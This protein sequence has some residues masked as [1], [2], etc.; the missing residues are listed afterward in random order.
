[1]KMAQKDYY[2]VLGVSRDASD[3]EI[4]A[5]YRKLARKFHPDV[6]KGS[7]EA[8]ERFKEVAEAFAVL[9]DKEKRARYDAVGHGAFGGRG[10]ADPFAGFDPR[11]LDLGFGDM[12]SLLEQMFGIRGGGRRTVQRRGRDL[13]AELR[14][15]FLQAVQGGTMEIQLP[16]GGPGTE[17]VKV[18]IPAGVEDGATLRLAGKGQEG[19]AGAGDAYLTIRVEGHPLF[20][21]EGRDLYVEVPVGIVRAT[22]G[23][24]VTVPTLDGQATVQLP[25]GT[26]SGRKLRLKGKGV[27]ARGGPGNLYAVIRIEPPTTLDDRSRELLE[28]LARHNPN[29]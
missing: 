5:A 11:D 13:R 17:A 22:L 23:G 14:V 20:R 16:R 12:S 6:N 1:M 21:R 15:P 19:P 25:A 26:A 7:A 24:G 2:E 4:K 27:P 3:K 29:A 18:R 9:S 8:E 28:E 10:G